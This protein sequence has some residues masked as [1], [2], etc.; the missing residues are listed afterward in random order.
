MQ[1]KLKLSIMLN[2]IMQDEKLKKRRMGGL[3]GAFRIQKSSLTEKIDEAARRY[4]ILFKSGYRT[5]FP[6]IQRSS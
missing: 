3:S 6:D 2:T 1:Y 5:L 4:I